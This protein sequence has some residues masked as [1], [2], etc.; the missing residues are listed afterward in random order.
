MM[1]RPKCS[2]SGARN[3]GAI[4]TETLKRHR[5]RMKVRRSVLNHAG[6]HVAMIDW[7]V[8]LAMVVTVTRQHATTVNHLRVA[9]QL[10]GF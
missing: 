5:P 3:I 2:L 7:D 9:L 1:L 8:A 4:A 10:Y 6:P